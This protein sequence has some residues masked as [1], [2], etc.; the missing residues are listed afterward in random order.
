MVCKV[1]EHA[2]DPGGLA[3][4]A[5]GARDLGV[6]AAKAEARAAR[7]GSLKIGFSWA[8]TGDSPAAS[9]WR[10]LGEHGGSA[11]ARALDW[12]GVD[13]YPGTWGPQI[14]AHNLSAGTTEALERTFADLRDQYM[15]LAGIPARVALHVAENGFPTGPGRTE[16]MQVTAVRAALETVNRDRGRYNITDYRWFDL[17]DAD[18]TGPSFESQYGLLRDDYSPK[19]AFAVFRGLVA[20]LSGSP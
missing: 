5:L 1:R 4:A 7:L 18:S 12:V 2:A 20:R 19:P 14:D 15:P 16:A 9:F 8:A 3:A 11:F 10:Y 17:R 13:V 6:I